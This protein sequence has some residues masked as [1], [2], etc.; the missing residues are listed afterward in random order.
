[1]DI[2]ILKKSSFEVWVPF[3]DD[4]EVLIAYQSGSDLRE[5]REKATNISWDR[6]HQKEE[7]YDNAMGNRLLGRAAVKDWRPRPGKK[8]FTL[9]GEGYPYTPE[10]CDFLM[11]KFTD[12]SNFVNGVC[13]DLQ[14]LVAAD[15][16]QTRKNSS[17]TSGQE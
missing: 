14:C 9:N 6:G 16:E 17:N 12:F 10:N 5:M 2:G 11:D 7:K 4:T 13:V 1:M 3:D 8:G 15:E